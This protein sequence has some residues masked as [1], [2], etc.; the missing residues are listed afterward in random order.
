MKRTALV[1]VLVLPLLL[2]GC[3]VVDDGTYGAA[4]YPQVS[5]YGSYGRPAYGYHPAPRPWYWGRPHG[6]YGHR[7]FHD[8]DRKRRWRGRGH[9]HGWR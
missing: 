5:V 3:Y 7:H 9:G 6:H 4:A 8:D 1:L 2:G